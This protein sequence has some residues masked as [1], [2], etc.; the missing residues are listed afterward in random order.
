MNRSHLFAA[1][2]LAGVL[3]TGHAAPALAQDSGDSAGSGDI[4][5]TARRSEERL[6]DVPISITVL[7]QDALS[8][9]NITSTADLG[10]YVPS[11]SVNSQFGP[12]KS[13]FVIR[14]FTQEYHT[15]PTVGVYFADVIAPRALGP[16]TSGNGAG[17]GSMFDLQN[18]QVLKGPQGTLFGRNTTGGAI[19]L[20]PA[21]PKD[22]FEGYVEASTGRFDQRRLEAVVNAPLSDTFRIRAGFDLNKRDG[23]L[24]NH[25][26]VGPDRFRDV[27]YFAG[28]LSIVGDLTPDLENYT[29][30]SYSRTNTKGDVPRMKYCNTTA[31]NQF[32]QTF[33]PALFLAFASCAQLARQDARGDGLWD[34][35]SNNPDPRQKVIQWQGINTTTWKASDSLTIKNIVSYA[36]YREWSDFSLWGDNLLIPPGF[37][38][39]GFLASKT[40]TL[41]G[42]LKGPT[43]A[44]RTMTEE[45]QFQG[46]SANG[47]LNWQVGAYL[48]VSKPLAWNS[49]LVEIFITCADVFTNKCT[50][51]NT[52]SISDASSKDWFNNKGLYAQGTYKLTDQLSLTGGLRY[53]MDKTRDVAQLLNIVF[54][55]A[56]NGAALYT[57][58]NRL[59][60]HGAGG[61]Q[62]PLFVPNSNNCEQELNLKSKR[63]TWLIDI[64]YKPSP[65]MLLYAK[66]ARGYRA[67]SITNN[68][69][70]FE[71][72]KPE[73][74]DSYE[75]GSKTSFR[76]AV[77]GYFNLS[78]FY[79]DF[80]NQQ[81]AT[82]SVIKP[83]W[84]GVIPP[85]APTV[86]AGKSRIWGIELDT[87]ISPF[88]G[89]RLDAAY[90]YLNTK[91]KSF[92]APAL[93][94]YYSQLL[95]AT[96]V[97]GPLPLSPKNRVTLT[98]NYTL[99]LADSVGRISFGATF[100]HTDKNQARS[101]SSTPA[102]LI[103]A[104]D[105]LNLNAS[106]DSVMG[107][108]FDLAFFM[109]NVTNEA[110]IVFPSSSYYTFGGDGGHT[111]EPRMW[112]VK[113]KYRFGE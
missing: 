15:A 9:R 30:F 106:W 99:P 25:S 109:T 29:I 14:G 78:A 66:W 62:D 100:V 54:P 8:K 61:Y 97:G 11:L 45:L 90:T 96:D 32:L 67:G 16:T 85:A 58:Q 73:T 89:L 111:N 17:V 6:Q 57:C 48:E 72:S 22:S 91:L 21:K 39:A 52:G 95:P 110:Y 49:Q 47:R 3:L 64:D 20:V 43:S 27:N 60:Y 101:P 37:P 13:S 2:A 41:N 7:D 23:Y 69:I 81:L 108:N 56:A 104:V 76:G 59:L 105:Q 74:V 12:E 86:N 24:K 42:G 33:N 68:S 4:I 40:I 94:I 83:E 44:Q 93:P 53:T 75:I 107:S 71:L 50:P 34:I 103:P 46:T 10:A 35:E 51:T 31:S 70:G 102:Y 84:Q 98:G 88:Q 26:G 80:R 82:G 19:L 77:P 5:V 1:T 112:G 113:L 55:T 28:R 63:A 65:D 38:G 79:N 36:E 92:V 87:S 18:L